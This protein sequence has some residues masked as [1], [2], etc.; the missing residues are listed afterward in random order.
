MTHMNLATDLKSDLQAHGD[1][2]VFIRDKL[3][4]DW[5]WPMQKEV[6]TEYYDPEKTYQ[7][8]VLVC[9]M[10]CLCGGTLVLTKNGTYK[11]VKQLKDGDEIYGLKEGK[12]VCASCTVKRNKGNKK[13]VQIKTWTEREIIVTTDHKI[14]TQRG[15]KEAKDLTLNDY[16]YVQ[17][18]FDIG[19]IHDPDGAAV[20]GYLISDGGLTQNNVKFSNYRDS[21]VKDFT[22]RVLRRFGGEVKHIDRGDYRINGIK[23]RNWLSVMGLRGC[24]AHNKFIPD[25][26]F[27]YDKESLSLFIYSLF[28]GDGCVEDRGSHTKI[29]YST[30][31]FEIADGVQKVL[32]KLRIRSYIRTEQHKH[33]IIVHVVDNDNFK[34]VVGDFRERKIKTKKNYSSPIDRIPFTIEDIGVKV[35]QAR[36]KGI[37]VNT[38]N[39][40]SLLNLKKVNENF[41]LRE[42]LQAIAN[43]EVFLDK[44]ISVC[45]SDETDTYD[46]CVDGVGNFFA[47]DILIKNSGKTTIA[48]I[49][50]C[51]EAFKLVSIGYPCKRYGLPPGSKIYIT[52]VATSAP[53]AKDTVFAAIKARI[54]NSPWFQQQKYTEHWNEF[55]FPVF[56]GEIII[57]SDHSNS[58][59]LV[60]R[61]Q[62]CVTFDELARFK[63]TKGN[64]SGEM[65]YDALSRSVKTFKK[66]GRRIAISSPML[67][68][69]FHMQLYRAGK[70]NPKKVYTRLMPTWDMNPNITYASLADEFARNPETAMRDYGAV[71]SAAI[72]SYFK[73]PQKID[74]CEDVAMINAFKWDE[75]LFSLELNPEWSPLDGV[76]YVLAGD[77]S[78][79]ND[80]FGMCLEHMQRGKY[81]IDGLGR[82]LPNTVDLQHE[83][84]TEAVSKLVMGV[85]EDM[86]LSDFV[87]DTW[88]FPETQ[89]RIRKKGV[90]TVNN[91]VKKEH[92]DFLKE[93]VYTHI[94]DW[95]E[96]EIMMTELKGLE[97]LRGQKVDHPKKGSKDVSDAAANATWI[98]GLDAGHEEQLVVVV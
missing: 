81:V 55:I 54:D 14:Y 47:E 26:V 96:S 6:I 16:I 83:I 13:C 33:G 30:V 8:M 65:V 22:E 56:D 57:R 59:S 68:T 91:V 98:L 23:I 41:S 84:D 69:D 71:P 48:S 40:L 2:E 80:S 61:T 50:A 87:T 93:K 49:C 76:R 15:L 4:I 35:Y 63:D 45:D 66:A 74:M 21:I 38:Q 77:P 20:L 73:E 3:K 28:S 51:Y 72:E 90:N 46:I 86:W 85:R 79:K 27:R 52:N 31:S 78:F 39:N 34:E 1:V 64:S 75:S 94:I 19:N 58:A 17:R 12:V 32:S 67:N 25:E 42:D 11:M 24:N 92:Y 95:P 18:K 88:M 60:G 9:G 36:K 10:R 53:Q 82:F 89:Q 7:D 70:L 37:S 43:D 29:T 44:V 97:L 5:L 62:I